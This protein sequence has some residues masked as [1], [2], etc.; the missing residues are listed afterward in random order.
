MKTHIFG[1]L[2]FICWSTLS[3]YFYV[4]KIQGFCY[5]P[6]S[7]PISLVKTNEVIVF[8]TFPEPVMVKPEIIQKKLVVYYAFDKSDFKADTSTLRNLSE[9]NAFLLKNPQMVLSIVGHTDAIGSEKYNL[10]LGYRRALELQKYF[11]RHGVPANKSVVESKGEL[12]PIDVN[13]TSK[14]RLNNR[15]TVIIIKK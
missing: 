7:L 3:T 1:L 12:E 13:Y 9:W 10:K 14:G 6:A 5:E 11:V 8:D 4:C 15:R 2:V